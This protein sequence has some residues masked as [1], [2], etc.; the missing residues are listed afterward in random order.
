MKKEIDN[1]K[2]EVNNGVNCIALLLF[3]TIVSDLIRN[4]H[5]DDDG[6]LEFPIFVWCAAFDGMTWKVKRRCMIV[7]LFLFPF[8]VLSHFKKK[9]YLSIFVLF[10]PLS[11]HKWWI[12]IFMVKMIKR[13]TSNI[14]LN[15]DLFFGSR[16]DA[17]C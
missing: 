5:D 9:F 2:I 1:R 8:H 4:L 7:V 17:V 15:L 11:C 10:L 14:L 12:F 13:S 3:F 16:C 6:T